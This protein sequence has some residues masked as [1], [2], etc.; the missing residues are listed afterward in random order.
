MRT[1]YGGPLWAQCRA[2][3]RS[4]AARNLSGGESNAPVSPRLPTQEDGAFYI[5]FGGIWGGQLQRWN[6]QGDSYNASSQC[7]TDKELPDAPAILPRFARLS[8]DLLSLAHP[9]REV[10]TA[11]PHTR[12]QGA[13][14]RRLL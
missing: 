10:S 1:A 8:D 5:F 13:H 2:R 7:T 3:A 12:P 4:A 9:P 6:T 14:R 11:L